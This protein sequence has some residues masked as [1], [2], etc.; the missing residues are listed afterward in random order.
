MVDLNEM[1]DE[2]KKREQALQ[3]LS[4]ISQQFEKA[5]LER[6]AKND[7]WWNGL[8]EAE[9]EDA[10][11]AVCKRIHKGDLQDNGS[12]RYVLYQTFGF[13]HGMYV[14]GM[15]CGYMAIHNA[16]FD[17]EELQRMKSVTRFEVIDDTGRAYTKYLKDGERVKYSL[18][19]DDRTLKV[20][21]DDKTWKDDL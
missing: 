9:R 11:Y 8:T 3:E 14:D 6:E 17:G 1:A 2:H 20:F 7:A 18:Q 19:D 4:D 12:Y 13:D 21:I 15:N 5:R 10:F 16:I